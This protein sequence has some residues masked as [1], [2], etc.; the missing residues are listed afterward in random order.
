MTNEYSRR[1]TIA[2]VVV[3]I[4]GGC[5]EQNQNP[6]GTD[7]ST[8][9]CSCPS[10]SKGPTEDS[11]GDNITTAEDTTTVSRK[12]QVE[13]LPERSPLTS[14]LTEVVAASDRKTVA[15]EHGIEFRESDHSVRVS[16]ELESNETLPDGYRVEVISSYGG[17]VIAWV[18]VD[19]L[20]P[21]AMEEDV[22][23]IQKP[24]ESQT[25]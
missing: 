13:R 23:K 25:H 10:G 4:T 1:A 15:A 2:G 24:A 6:A 17:R 22:R 8:E 19:D 9:D 21:L 5:V 11:D 18:H 12:E 3:L 16:I 7:S 20:V 14:S